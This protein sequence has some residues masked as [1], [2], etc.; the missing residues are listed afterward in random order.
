MAEVPRAR[1]RVREEAE[2]VGG[3]MGGERI[4]GHGAGER[5]EEG[6]DE[7]VEEESGQA[8]WCVGAGAWPGKN[9]GRLGADPEGFRCAGAGAG[10]S[11]EGR[12]KHTE[13]RAGDRPGGRGS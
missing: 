13:N 1:V 6:R 9:Q 5:G 3:P 2:L 4:G 7:G 8:A 11:V 10:P 12:E